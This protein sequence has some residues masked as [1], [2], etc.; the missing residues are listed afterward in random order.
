MVNWTASMTRMR[1][2]HDGSGRAYGIVTGM[3]VTPAAALAALKREAEA[4]AQNAGE[5]AAKA[6]EAAEQAAE[7][8]AK[9]P[10]PPRARVMAPPHAWPHVPGP[11]TPADPK[12]PPG[13][14]RV[15]ATRLPEEGARPVQPVPAE[16]H[17][18]RPRSYVFEVVDVRLTPAVTEDGGSGWL[19]YGTLAL[20]R[21]VGYP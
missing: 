4:L 12:L 5:R 9:N 8:A 20:A 1:T 13:A 18:D 2:T 3:D 15:A 11:S 14:R 10:P 7:A 16:P 17:D 19:A 21:E 6:A